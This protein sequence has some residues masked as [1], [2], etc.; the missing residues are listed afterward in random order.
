MCKRKRRAREAA[1][2]P[3]S[4]FRLCLATPVALWG[5]QLLEPG[6]LWPLALQ[7]AAR[8]RPLTPLAP[9][10]TGLNWRGS[11]GPGQSPLAATSMR[12]HLL[13]GLT[14]PFPRGG[15]GLSLEEEVL[16]NSVVLP[17][18]HEVRLGLQKYGREC[19]M[20]L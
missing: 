2:C 6:E 14:T 16:L 3:R 8:H 1:R 12:L 17:D 15:G 13:K 9:S 4:A 18:C 5:K 10:L 20:C 19:E 7:A 11:P